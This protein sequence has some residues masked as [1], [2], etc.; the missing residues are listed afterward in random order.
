MFLEEETESERKETYVKTEAAIVGRCHIDLGELVSR[1]SHKRDSGIHRRL[2]QM[3]HSS[4]GIQ[5]CS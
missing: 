5:R 2:D 1:A 3:S 4:C